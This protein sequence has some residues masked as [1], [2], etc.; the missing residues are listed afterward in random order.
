MSHFKSAFIAL[1]TIIALLAL[2]STAFAVDPIQSVLNNQQ[3][4]GNS[5][6]NVPL[7]SQQYVQ[8]NLNNNPIVK[9]LDIFVTGLTG[10]VGVVIVANIVLAG[11]QYST[12][13]GN[14][15]TTANARKRIMN[16]FLAL[17]AFLLI[18]AFAQ[19]LIPG[20]VFG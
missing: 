2:P 11:I 14:Q 19:W 20:G 13:G 6:S 7:P 12:A 18:W 8:K 5:G 10:L 15:Q 1:A 16:S 4:S 17:F 3:S 9:D